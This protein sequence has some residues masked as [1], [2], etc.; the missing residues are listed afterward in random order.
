MFWSPIVGFA[1]F[2]VSSSSQILV[3]GLDEIEDEIESLLCS[4][5]W[6]FTQFRQALPVA[7]SSFA[8]CISA[9]C[10]Q[11]EI[12]DCIVVG[13][14]VVGLA[15]GRELVVR[16][17][18]TLILEKTDAICAGAS[19]GNSGIGCTGYVSVCL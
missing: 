9:D 3:G 4:P 2:A 1:L 6:M 7:V 18:S 15:V 12:H 13:G 8:G 10:H 19:S 11:D 17:H 16:G 14:G 5:F